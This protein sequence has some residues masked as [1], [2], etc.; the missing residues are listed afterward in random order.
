MEYRRQTRHV[1]SVASICLLA[2]S[3][4]AGTGITIE[5]VNTYEAVCGNLPNEIANADN[6]RN[7]MLSRPGFTAGERWVETDVFATDFTDVIFGGDDSSA[8]FDRSSF[9][10]AISFFAGHGECKFTSSQACTASAQCTSPLAGTMLPGI[11][12]RFTS[13]PLQ[14]RCMYNK[15]RS[16]I[17]NQNSLCTSSFYPNMRWGE[18][19]VQSWAGAGTDGGVNFAVVDN[20]C[21]VQPDLFF[22]NLQ[23]VFAGLSTFAGVMPTR[24]GSDG[25]SI[26]N[27][28]HAFAAG[29]IVNEN[30]SIAQSWWNAINLISSDAGSSCQ[31]GGGGRGV[32]GCGAYITISMA[33][34]Q[35]SAVWARD[36]EN[37]VHI[38]DDLNDSAGNVWAAWGYSC[39]YDCNNNYWTL[40]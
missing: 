16:I 25:V 6:F 1:V 27:R 20:S 14:G 7:R 35:A 17:S 12:L 9:R 32:N 31:F 30:S 36:T 37:W 26:P 23:G 21:P 40:F 38:R 13:S 39:N 19:T 34:D 24:N 5:A 10:D 2:N 3:A 4:F 28:G 8:G 11:C 33:A 22:Q 15:D 29:Y 18:S